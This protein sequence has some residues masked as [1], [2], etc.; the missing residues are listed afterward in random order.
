MALVLPFTPYVEAVLVMGL[1]T[2]APFGLLPLCCTAGQFVSA[3]AL[4]PHPAYGCLYWVTLGLIN[5]SLITPSNGGLTA[6]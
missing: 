2:I 1:S 3:A 4:N 5:P 6:D